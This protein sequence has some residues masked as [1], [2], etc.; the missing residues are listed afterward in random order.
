VYCDPAG[1][2]GCLQTAYRYRVGGIGD[3]DNLEP[4]SASQIG[5]A[6]VNHQVLGISRKA[7]RP[8]SNRQA[9]VGYIDDPQAFQTISQEDDAA[10][11]G[12]APGRS[13]TVVD[14]YLYRLLWVE[15]AEQ[16]Q[17]TVLSEGDK[18]IPFPGQHMAGFSLRAEQEQVSDHDNEN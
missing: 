6:T 9:R 15:Q 16:P 7:D 11:A 2:P 17:A 10:G 18:G 13:R 1:I 12:D 4:L 8:D 3:I 14:T 5:K